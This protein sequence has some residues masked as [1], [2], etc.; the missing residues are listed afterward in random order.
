MSAYRRKLARMGTAGPGQPDDVATADVS[1]RQALV[2][3]RRA[4]Q[5]QIAWQ[6][7]TLF[8][9]VQG[10][11]IGG[12]FIKGNARW[13]GIA[14]A[15]AG[16]LSAAVFGLTYHRART[17]ERVLSSWLGHFGRLSYYTLYEDLVQRGFAPVNRDSSGNIAPP[18][19]RV[20]AAWIVIFVI[21]GVAWA[22]Y[23]GWELSRV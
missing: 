21:V 4:G 17:A 13:G 19:I 8:F 18:G 3:R 7:L 14:E 12:S 22:G 10:V 9:I 1:D 23:L 11:L 6:T 5:E 15:F 2:E 16:V 20:F